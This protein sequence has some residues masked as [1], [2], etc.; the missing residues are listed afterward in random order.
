MLFFLKIKKGIA[1]SCL[2]LS[3]AGLTAC[4]EDAQTIKV[5]T[6]AGPETELAQFAATL[7]AQQSGLKIKIITFTD[8]LQ[9]NAA[10][11]AGELQANIFQHTPYLQ[12]QIQAHHYDLTAVGKTFFYPMGIYSK[13]YRTLSEVPN[14]AQVAIPNDPTNEG[15]ALL[16][17]QQAGLIQLTPSADGP[18]TLHNITDNP[19]HLSFVELDAA[20]LPRA[21]RDV[22]LA[23]INTNYAIPA[24]LIPAKDAVFME[25]DGTL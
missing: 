25:R 8:Y 4:Q 22:A 5:G 20:Q 24:G 11:D 21:F 1:L 2:A 10:L 12:E 9:P 19:K 7:A 23:V 13:Q 17:V 15:R 6:I 16:L 3:C 14:N 18:A